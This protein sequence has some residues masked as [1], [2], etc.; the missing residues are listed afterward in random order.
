MILFL[1]G[2]SDARELAVLLQNEGYP[3]IATVVT[4][5][6]A[7]S[8]QDEQIQVRVGRLPQP[9]MVA[10]AKEQGVTTIVDASHPFAEEASKNAMAAAEELGVPYIRYERETRSYIHHPNV[11]IVPDYQTAALAAKERKGVVMLTT[12]SKTLGIFAK[13]LIGDPDIRLVARMLPRKDNME[14]CEELGVEQKNIVAM[15]GPFSKEMNAALYQHYGVTTM[16][17]KESGQVGAVDE[18]LEAAM[19]LGIF[20]IMIDRPKLTYGA[21]Y[22]DFDGVLQALAANKQA[23]AVR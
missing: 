15:Q 18:K 3:L 5:S 13:H 4:D 23:Q 21:L 2:T 19:E 20:T 9:E 17:T 11:Q 14:K 22:S 8:L 10:F 7:K 1:A 16:I 12:G 6:A